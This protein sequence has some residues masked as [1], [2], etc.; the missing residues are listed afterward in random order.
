MNIKFTI[1][2]KGTNYCGW[3]IQQNDLTIQSV[4]EKLLGSFNGKSSVKITCA[5]RTDSGVHA[6]GQVAHF[7]LNTDLDTCTLMKA[8]N[9][10]QVKFF[11]LKLFVLI[12]P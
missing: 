2:Y 6:L 10:C 1:E 3:Q 7:D 4:L 12:H 11:L 5:G 9:A 8:I